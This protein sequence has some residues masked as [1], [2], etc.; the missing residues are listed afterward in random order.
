MSDLAADEAGDRGFFW[1]GGGLCTTRPAA[2]LGSWF[3]SWLDSS[4]LW[5]P[6]PLGLCLELAGRADGRFERVWPGLD[7]DLDCEC[8]LDCELSEMS[9][10]ERDD[11]PTP[12]PTP[13]PLPPLSSS[14]PSL[15]SSSIPSLSSSSSAAAADDDDD[16]DD[17]TVCLPPPTL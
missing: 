11:E 8:D 15:S 17:D 16:D 13:T 7:L 12:T 1:G 3:G 9:D 2:R 6:P 5:P 10:R 4:P 14:I